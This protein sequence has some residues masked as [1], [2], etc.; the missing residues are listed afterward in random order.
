PARW[1]GDVLGLV[2]YPFFPAHKTALLS[3]GSHPGPR[4]KYF[5]SMWVCPATGSGFGCELRD[6]GL[7]EAPEKER[8][9]QLHICGRR[10]PL[11]RF[12]GWR[13][14]GSDHTRLAFA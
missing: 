8:L 3:H 6:R 13:L 4:G 10:L 12:G 5:R 2:P 9:I 1:A 11:M 7:G 14:P